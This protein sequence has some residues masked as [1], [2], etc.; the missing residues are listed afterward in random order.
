MTLKDFKKLTDEEVCALVNKALHEYDKEIDFHLDHGIYREPRTLY[1]MDCDRQGVTYRLV[2]LVL[3]DKVELT[4]Y[5]Q[6]TKIDAFKSDAFCID[7]II[8]AYMKYSFTF[9]ESVC[10]D[11]ISYEIVVRF[12]N[13]LTKLG[14]K[15]GY[16]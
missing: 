14:K 10:L 11:L 1:I 3:K 13:G 8:H 7:S 5:P 15:L 16:I 2:M 12:M 4:V 9:K 6:F